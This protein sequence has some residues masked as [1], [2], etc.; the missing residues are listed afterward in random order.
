[1]YQALLKALRINFLNSY[2]PQGSP[3]SSWKVAGRDCRTGHGEVEVVL[4]GHRQG[5]GDG[6]RES[7]EGGGVG[8]FGPGKPRLIL[9]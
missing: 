7:S 1:M 8:L 3:L 4:D 5:Q 6:W 9:A 2:N